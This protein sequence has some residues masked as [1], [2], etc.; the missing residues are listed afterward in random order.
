MANVARL[1]R[2]FR[3]RSQAEIEA[4]YREACRIDFVVKE[5]TG[6]SELSEGA[7][8]ELLNWLG[9]DFPDF[10]RACFLWSIDHGRLY[11]P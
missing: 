8:E 4:I 6:T 2:Q 3:E 7:R 1:C 10:G 11:A 9:Q 5:L